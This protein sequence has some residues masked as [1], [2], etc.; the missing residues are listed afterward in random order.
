MTEDPRLD[1]RYQTPPNQTSQQKVHSMDGN[2]RYDPDQET[3]IL[4]RIR[5]TPGLAQPRWFHNPSFATL[6][7]PP[8]NG[9]ICSST[10]AE[11]CIDT[12][13]MF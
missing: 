3:S 6:P 4:Q 11:H 7:G 12:D 9:T 8:P 13:T 5:T 1:H 2:D 10:Q